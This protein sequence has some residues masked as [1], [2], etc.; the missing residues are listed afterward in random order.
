MN[1]NSKINGNNGSSNNGFN[2]EG[3]IIMT[4]GTMT[5]DA[6]AGTVRDALSVYF[7]DCSIQLQ[8]VTKNNGLI[9]H[10]LCIREEDSNIAPTIY[11]EGFYEQYQAGRSFVDIVK[12]IARVY[13]D[14][15]VTGSFNPD[16]IMDYERIKDYICGKVVNTERNTTLLSDVPSVPFCDLSIIFFVKLPDYKEQAA[17]ITIHNSLMDSWGVDTD[18]LYEVAKN[19]TPRLLPGNVCSMESVLSG[20]FYDEPEDFLSTGFDDIRPADE[21]RLYVATNNVRVNGATVFL[22]DNLLSGFAERI[23]ADFFIL[24][25]SIHELLFLPDTKAMDVET[26]RD[27]VKSVNTSEV[28]PEEVLSDNVYHYC[29]ETGLVEIA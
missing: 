2:N 12:E 20:L 17:S 29:R 16:I 8:E 1:N 21:F 18:T 11:L 28:R 15:R 14:N 9:L 10:G 6:F 27:M 7:E 26:M 13:E 5:M 3:G 24:P 4:N 22:Y 25:S 23:G 19:N